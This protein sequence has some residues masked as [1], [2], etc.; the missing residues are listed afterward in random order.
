MLLARDR[1][2][3][4]V[5]FRVF[6]LGRCE[7]RDFERLLSARMC[8]HMCQEPYPSLILFGCCSHHLDLLFGGEVVCA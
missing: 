1:T 6:A 7:L 4:L 8:V 2:L 5:S 3:L